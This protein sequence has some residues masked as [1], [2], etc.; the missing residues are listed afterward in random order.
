MSA[1]PDILSPE[2]AQDPYPLCD[3]LRENH[4]VTYHEAT[5]SWI[6]S[7]HEDIS[8]AFKES[9]YTT[10]NYEWQLEP[11]HGRTILQMEGREHSVH[12]NLIAPAFRGGEL[13]TKFLPVI[14]KNAADLIATF[15]MAGEVDLVQQFTIRFPINVIV[16][17]LGLDKSDHERF[18]VWYHSIMAFL[19]NLTADPD[20]A[21]QGLQTKE[22]LATYMMPI[23]AERRANPGEDLLST[24]CTA[25]VDGEKMTDEIIKAF[26]SLLL[27]AGGETTDKAMANM[28]MNLIENPDQM[29]AVRNDRALIANAFAE[30]LRFTPPVLMVMRQPAEDVEIRGVTIPAGA[31]I[32][33]LVP[34]ANRD[35]RVF[36]NPNRF[37]IFRDDL[38]VDKAFTAA[39]SHTSFALGRHFC[40]GAM[41]SKAEVE[42]GANRLLD[43]MRDIQFAGD[44]PQPVG[45]FTRAPVSMPLT[46]TPG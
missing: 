20:V 24:L 27:V 39:A 46:F 14:E 37:D 16:D 6:I 44:A 35:P 18:Q 3:E 29:Q 43:A 33:C 26:V 34:S 19:S 41:L 2:F 36:S 13:Q 12:R 42:A 17:M 21:A 22:E 28:F 31:T 9:S 10:R 38:P 11:V 15:A 45:V 32:T 25:E 5:Q 23:I 30:T 8:A 40:I 1:P 7:R 4:P